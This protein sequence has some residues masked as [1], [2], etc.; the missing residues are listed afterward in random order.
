MQ[1]LALHAT[2]TANC[3][4]KRQYP[5]SRRAGRFPNGLT[6]FRGKDI[7]V[8]ICGK[9]ADWGNAAGPRKWPSM[10]LSATW[11]GNEILPASQRES[12]RNVSSIAE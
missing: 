8:T 12:P 4:G 5:R 3:C 11:G 6:T 1:K 10:D 9:K 7:S 2:G